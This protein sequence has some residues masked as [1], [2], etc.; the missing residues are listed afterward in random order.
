M[1]TADA[2]T[3]LGNTPAAGQYDNELLD[4]HFVAGDA[5]VNEN[6]VLTSIHEVFHNEHNR[7]V[8]Q[9]EDMIAQRDQIQPGFAAQWTGEMIFEAA[10]LAN[11]MQYQHIVFE[12]FARRMSPNITA[13]AE[14]QVEINPNITA[15]FSQAVFRLGHSMLTDTVDVVNAAD[16]GTSISLVDAFLNP[17]DLR[18]HWVPPTSSRA[19]PSR[20]ATRSTSSSSTPCATSWSACR[21]TWPPSTSPAAATSASGRSMT[22]AATCSRRPAGRVAHPLCELGRFRRPPAAPDIAGELHRR[23]FAAGQHRQRPQCR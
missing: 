13:F 3:T 14:Y 11:E 2:D 23:L 1:L 15:E 16:Q 10:K 5:R 20:W 22:C 21:S 7:L 6:V 17:L 12:F 9:V 18:R 8:A 19:C 4:A